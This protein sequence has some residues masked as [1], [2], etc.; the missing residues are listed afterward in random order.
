MASRAVGAAANDDNA[1]DDHRLS[2]TSATQRNGIDFSNISSTAATDTNRRS[3]S[4]QQNQPTPPYNHT[5]HSIHANANQD[6]AAP[7]QYT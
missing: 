7:Q 5:R 1:A 6:G 2:T 4:T 3:I